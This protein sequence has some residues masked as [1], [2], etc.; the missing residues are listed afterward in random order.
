MSKLNIKTA[1]IEELENK[2]EEVLGTQFGHNMIG[3][4]CGVVEERFG[5]EEANRFEDT[6]QQ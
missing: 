5:E 3:I 4:I 6:Y 2:C 1:T